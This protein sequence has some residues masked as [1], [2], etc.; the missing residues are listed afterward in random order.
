MK[1]S[2]ID[3]PRMYVKA[4][5][6][7]LPFCI[8]ISRLTESPTKNLRLSWMG[9]SHGNIFSS[10]VPGKKPM[11]LPIGW[12]GRETIRREY[13]LLS[14]IACCKPAAIAQSVFPDP[15]RPISETNLID[16]SKSI[17][18]AKLCSLF[19]GF[20]FQSG[21]LVWIIFFKGLWWSSK[22]AKQVFFGLAM[23]DNNKYWFE[24]NFSSISTSS[25]NI[26]SSE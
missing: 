25:K 20:I 17:S 19:L 11:S 22:R 9:I 1:A 7:I 3:L 12:T 2:E 13:K 16:G 23:D 5:I 15:A 18:I 21:M 6:S 26:F 4:S 24:Y 10:I 14:P 8:Y